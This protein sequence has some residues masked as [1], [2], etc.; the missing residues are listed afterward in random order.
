MRTITQADLAVRLRLAI[1]RTARRL[2][3]EAGEE[4][5][6]EQFEPGRD[7]ILRLRDGEMKAFKLPRADARP[8]S[9]A[10]DR[11]G[12]AYP[13]SGWAPWGGAPNGRPR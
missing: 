7:F 8:S 3:Q 12:F 6:V 11:D 5:S 2:R 13:D 4:L 10:V 1:A 9:V